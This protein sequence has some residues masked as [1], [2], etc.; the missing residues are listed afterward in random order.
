MN[1]RRLIVALDVPTARDAASLVEKLGDA[2]EFYK[3]G[4]E[5]YVSAGMSFVRD[6]LSANKRV[7][8][9]MKFYDIGETVKRA[10]A[11]VASSGVH[12]LTIHGSSAVMKAAVEGKQDAPLK[13]LAVTVLT[14]FDEQDLR[15]LGYPVSVSDL[16]DLRV[17]KARESGIDGV[18][19]SP[20]EVARVR[21]LA[22][23]EAILVTPGV[24]SAGAAGDQ[25]R[26][27]TPAEATK[28]GA[29]YLVIGRQIT[30]AADPRAAAES[31]GHEIAES[32]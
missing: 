4:M 2:I 32:R 16:V 17:L 3:V 19:C 14:S 9:D 8:L 26:I 20:V 18:V 30:R 29:N 27:A 11:A 5:L 1:A 15:D 10:V 7:F 23:P 6:L 13:L 28:N 31:I 21:E 24:R 25:K 22:G 12:F